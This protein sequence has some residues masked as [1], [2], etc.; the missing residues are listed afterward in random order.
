MIKVK[1]INP[2]VI[3]LLGSLPLIFLFQNC[4]K[5]DLEVASVERPSSAYGTL[6]L[7]LPPQY[8]LE[9]V[10]AMNLNLTFGPTGLEKD[11]DADGVSDQEEIRLGLDPFKRR[12]F[13]QISDRLCLSLSPDGN[14]T[15]LT[16]NC[17][18]T[19]TPLGLTVCEIQTLGLDTLVQNPTQGL[20]SDLD[21]IIDLFEVLRGTQVNKKDAH[22]DPDRDLLTNS[23]EF[24]MG[25]NPI[26]Y[27]SN[28]KE[29]YHTEIS[30]ERIQDEEFLPECYQEKWRVS[31]KSVAFI[32][33]LAA[34]TDTFNPSHPDHL[35]FSR[36]AGYNQVLIVLKLQPQ[37]GQGLSV[38]PRFYF[39]SVLVNHLQFV[40]DGE[41]KDFT[42]AGEVAH[43]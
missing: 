1:K 20:D 25:S 42:L 8:T 3:V 16:N 27:T 6:E 33:D 39:R 13:G 35:N 12:S 11:S 5:A 24:Q 36:P 41:I 26:R 7:C 23:Q 32:H 31:I 2:M 18:L 38:L 43:D 15:N 37:L 28:L 34:F 14:C 4:S 30:S 9:S 22:E 29:L 40:L 21:G 19:T 10:L 17:P